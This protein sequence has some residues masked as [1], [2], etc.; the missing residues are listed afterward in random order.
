MANDVNFSQVSNTEHTTGVLLEMFPLLGV[1]VFGPRFY[2]NTFLVS[3][4]MVG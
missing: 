4:K 3:N 2:Y 1:S